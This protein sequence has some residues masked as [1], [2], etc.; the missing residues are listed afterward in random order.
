MSK[1]IKS[2]NAKEL[3][4]SVKTIN[5]RQVFVASH[6]DQIDIH[7][8]QQDTGKNVHYKEP[9]KLLIEAQ[10]HAGALLNEAYDEIAA[11]RMELEQYEKNVLNEAEKKFTEAEKSGRKQ[12]YEAGVLEGRQSYDELIKKAEN[13]VR[14]AQEDYFL[15]VEKAESDLL[16]LALKVAEKIIGESI[17]KDHNAWIHLV[18]EAVKEVRE[19]E[20]VKIYVPVSAY[21]LTLQ[22]EQEIKEIA[23]HTRH[24]YIYPDSSLLK[25]S[26]IIETPFGK[27]NA[28]IDSQ[29]EEMKKALHEMLKAGDQ[30][31]YS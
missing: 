8:D 23:L 3:D 4:D 21:E 28:S 13:A 18:K 9:E 14:K 16:D 24:L 7:E 19:Q 5:V 6:E 22:H 2:A 20:E 15:K 29:L 25:H 11:K 31:E 1:L 27:V 12:G 17:V 30:D 10:Q 26:C